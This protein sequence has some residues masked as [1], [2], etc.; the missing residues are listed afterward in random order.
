MKPPANPF[1]AQ[2]RLIELAR[3]LDRHL[4]NSRPHQTMVSGD[5]MKWFIEAASEHLIC[6]SSLDQALG[7]VQKGAGRPPTERQAKLDLALR[8]HPLLP[9]KPKRPNWWKIVKDLNYA[10]TANELR[11]LYADH[12][13]DDEYIARA[14]DRE[15]TDAIKQGNEKR[16]AAQRAA[17]KKSRAK[18]TRQ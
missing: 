3:Q 10:G 16:A 7:L 15:V 8:V 1:E 12:F 13:D 11:K 18:L 9:L 14:I 2:Q 17:L 6:Q 4:R 5:L